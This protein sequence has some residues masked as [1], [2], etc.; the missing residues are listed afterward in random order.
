M[1]VIEGARRLLAAGSDADVDAALR[2]TAERP[3][4]ER[5]ALRD[6]VL[7]WLRPHLR[8]PLRSREFFAKL[9]PG[10]PEDG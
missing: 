7:G 6:L 10:A 2:A 5:R 1:E 9:G 8:Q 4:S 3:A